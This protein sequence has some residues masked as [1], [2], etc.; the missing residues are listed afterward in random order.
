MDYSAHRP[1]GYEEQGDSHLPKIVRKLKKT[2]TETQRDLTYDVLL[3][4][5][6]ALGELAG[7]L[8]DFVED[9]HADTGIWAAYERYNVEFFGTALPLTSDGSGSVPIADRVRHFLWILYPMLLDGLVLSPIHQDLRRIA[10]TAASFLS[11]TFAEVPMDSG[12]KAFFQSSNASGGDVKGKLL[13]LGTHSFLFRVPFARYMEEQNDTE[14]RVIAHMDD[15]VCQHCTRWSGLGVPDILARVLDISEDDRRDL[16]SWYERH[17]AFYKIQSVEKQGIEVLNLINDQPYRVRIELPRNPFRRGQVVFG[18]LVPWRGEWYWSG[19]QQLLGNA[20]EIDANGLKQVMKRQNPGIV[21][22]YSKEYEEQVRRIFSEMHEKT[23]AYHGGQ[24]LTIYP[25]GLTMAA[26]WQKEAQWHWD[27]RPRKEVE[28][29]VRKHE[30]TKGRPEIELSNDLLEEKDELGVFLNP[31]EGKEIMSSFITL[32]SGLRKKGEGL[33]QDEQEVIRGFF[34][35]PAISPRFVRRVLG[36]YG[37]ES[38]KAAFLLPDDVPG[39]WLD[40]ILRSYK[41]HFYRNRYPTL[42]VA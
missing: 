35:S 21:A 39:Y 24:D 4:P 37:D 27:Q 8:V 22:R 1:Q 13:W 41:G 3:L 38:A 7:I 40:Y 25:D 33:T 9:L 15:F 31:D 36:E 26:D 14:E 29:A 11:D 10:D 28:E 42:G 19:E 2:L 34:D 6:R 12:V 17:T 30:L 20:S 32:L 16:R 5:S 23:L 18:S